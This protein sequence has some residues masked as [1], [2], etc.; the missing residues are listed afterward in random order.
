MTRRATPVTGCSVRRGLAVLATALFAAGWT[1]PTAALAEPAVVE[2]APEK[3]VGAAPQ[4]ARVKARLVADLAS[5]AP[6]ATVRVGVEFTIAE[7]WHMYWVYPGDVGLPTELRL[8]GPD[9]FAFGEVRWP[10]PEKLTTK[11]GL[12]SYGYEGSV[13]PWSEVRVPEGALEGERVTLL[14]HA[15]WLVCAENCIPGSAALTLELPIESAARPSAEAQVL[16]SAAATVPV[17]VP[18]DARVQGT[19]SRTGVAP[20]ES[21]EAVFIIESADGKPFAD[22]ELFPAPA[23]GLDTT[24][25]LVETSGPHIPAGGVL[26]RVAGTASSDPART[27]D[28]LDAVLK[29][30][31]GGQPV[32]W[33]F[34]L[35]VPRLPVGQAGT[36]VQSALFATAVPAPGAPPPPKLEAAPVESPDATAGPSLATMLLFALLGGLIL[37]VMPCVL[38]VL[39]IKVLGLVQQSEEDRRGIWY[40][41]V[42]YTAG[43]LLSFAVMGAVLIALKASGEAVGW[44]FQFQE[45]VFVAV[46]GAIVF[47]FGLSLFGVFEVEL[48]GAGTL[49][50]KASHHHSYG[51]SFMNGV[52]ATLLATPCT[53]PFLAPALGFALAQ[54]A[55]ILMGFLLTIGFGLALPFL[56]LAAVP[57]WARHLPK[58]GAWMNTLKKAMGFLLM[59]TTVWLIDVLA[60]QW[61]RDAMTHYLAFL[62]LLAFAAWVYGHWGGYGFPQRTRFA[63]LALSVAL[64][65]AGSFALFRQKTSAPDAIAW[66]DFASV[67]VEALAGQGQ[68][69]FIDFTADWCVTCKVY[70]R[71]VIDT[72]SIKGALAEGCVTSVRADYTKEDPQITR[73][74]ERFQRPGVPMYLILPAGRPGEP[75]LLPDVLTE[76]SLLEGLKKAGPTRG[77]CP[78]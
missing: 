7:D 71:T 62:T 41:G 20:G 16:A 70:E 6:G 69:V 67:D 37:N 3:A 24:G 30:T 17:S 11:N 65:A 55:L 34:S 60:G 1:V 74:L 13:V 40:H 75:V 61:E 31:R 26:V 57:S 72:D 49:G 8:E 27:G 15:E 77:A 53:A 10:V 76:S 51:G 43:I 33:E 23:D 29:A 25:V 78:G 32:A 36:P 52:L 44:G 63:A 14:A 38:P 5:V 35:P 66:Q 56:L 64:V 46:M 45:P 2:A 47:A 73:W 58:P 59:A 21:F 28:R 9:G 12:V 22:P 50:A 18:S 39:S 19:L 68:T 4:E 42:A 54:P 48:P